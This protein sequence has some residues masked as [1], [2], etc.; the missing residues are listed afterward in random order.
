MITSD[1][2]LVAV[3]V[4]VVSELEVRGLH[5]VPRVLSLGSGSGEA[6]QL[7]AVRLTSQKGNF[8]LDSTPPH[9]YHNALKRKK[10]TLLLQLSL[11]I[12]SLCINLPVVVALGPCAKSDSQRDK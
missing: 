8:Q 7:I 5:G 1:V 12:P 3:V 6:R 9:V 11:S 4:S 10:N 2:M